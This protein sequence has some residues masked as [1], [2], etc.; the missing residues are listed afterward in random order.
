MFRG[1][2]RVFNSETALIDA[3]EHDPDSFADHDM[4][5]IRPLAPG[6][7]VSDY[8]SLASELL[9]LARRLLLTPRT[10]LPVEDVAGHHDFRDRLQAEL[11]EHLFRRGAVRY[12]AGARPR[13]GAADARSHLQHQYEKS[14]RR[15]R[16]GA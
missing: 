11:R 4:V 7:V 2:A 6:D 8:P 1:R 13:R 9:Q 10:Q 16:A 12:T 15:R 5:V 14:H 3:L